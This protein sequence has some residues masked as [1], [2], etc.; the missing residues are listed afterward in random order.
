[1]SNICDPFYQEVNSY[2][3]EK[4][5]KVDKIQDSY[6]KEYTKD[7]FFKYF[8]KISRQWSPLEWKKKTN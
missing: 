4:Y 1:M 7:I 2:L 5:S 3:E 6:K 8:H